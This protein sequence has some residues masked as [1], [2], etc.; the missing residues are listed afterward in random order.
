MRAV[1]QRVRKA[2]VQVGTERVAEIGRGL[3]ILL[4][5]GQEDGEEEARWLAEKIARLRLFDNAEG[6]LN[7]SLLEV[8][9]EALV[10]S[11]FTLYGD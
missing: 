11:Q 7:H 5:V 1:I 9:G 6:K 2:S 10:V 4:G 8:G 3:L